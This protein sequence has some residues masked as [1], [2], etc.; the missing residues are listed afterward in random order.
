MDAIKTEYKRII[1]DSKSEAVFARTLDLGGHQW[2]YHPPEHCGHVWDFLVFRVHMGNK[3]EQI[4]VEYKPKMPTDTY[5]DELTNRMRHDPK[6]SIVVWGNP[7]D[8]VD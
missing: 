2:S 7:W 1:F 6:E 5:V 8:G 4:L 3:S